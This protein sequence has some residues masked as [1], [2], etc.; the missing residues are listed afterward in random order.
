MSLWIG[1]CQSRGNIAADGTEGRRVEQRECED[2]KVFGAALCVVSLGSRRMHD[3]IRGNREDADQNK[4]NYDSKDTF[5]HE[6]R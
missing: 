1:R 4:S 5:E 6:S 3:E 2:D